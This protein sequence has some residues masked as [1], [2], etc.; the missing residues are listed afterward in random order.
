MW[1]F[2]SSK[3]Q[4]D[5]KLWAAFLLVI[6]WITPLGSN[7][8]LHPIINNLFLIAPV[9]V[10]LF[11]QCLRTLKT[12]TTFRADRR[13]VTVSVCVM[14]LLCTTV[15]SILFGYR[16]IFH[17]AG[18]STEQERLSELNCATVTSGLKTTAEKKQAIEGL[19]LYLHDSEL[20]K[21]QVILYGDIPALAYIL[22]ME[23]AVFTT[24]ADLDSNR[25]S[26]LERDLDTL[27]QNGETPVVILGKEALNIRAQLGKTDAKLDAINTFMEA[28]DYELLYENNMFSVYHTNVLQ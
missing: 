21:K 11:A 19:D 17:D 13:F 15:Q 25:L 12:D 6:I 27:Y 10:Y 9:S 18:A 4:E 16:F 5:S 7:N 20:N 1:T 22:D 26:L 2:F 14:I 28:S 8:R 24:W 3:I 23:P